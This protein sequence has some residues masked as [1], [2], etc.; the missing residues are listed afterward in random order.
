MSRTIAT[1]KVDVFDVEGMNVSGKVTQESE[2]DVDQE[3]GAAAG[4]EIYTNGRD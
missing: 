4:N 2:A 1:V 3:V